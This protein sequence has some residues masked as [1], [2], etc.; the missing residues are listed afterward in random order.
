MTGAKRKSRLFS[1]FQYTQIM[2]LF[3]NPISENIL[4][5]VIDHGE[6]RQ[7]STIPKG[8][9]YDAFPEEVDRMIHR[10]NI[11]TIWCI[12]WPWS[13]TRMR[14]VTLT[15]NTFALTENIK[16]KG[17]H[18]FEIINHQNPIL[19]AN[20]REYIVLEDDRPTLK[21]KEQLKVGKEYVGYGQKNDFTD[22]KNF[23]EY[24]LDIP[25]I[26]RIFESRPIETRLSP[27]YL[28]EPHITWS[29]KNT[30]PSSKTMS[31]SSWPSTD[32]G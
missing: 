19:I 27:I 10:H 20:N 9:D 17:C 30:Y 4:L 24:T 1:N 21:E 22:G 15:L 18:F 5:F 23:I 2:V 32:I 12:V 16:L 3:I 7:T 26:T 8:K 13:F 31:K 29:K 6:V 28:K 11:D 14:I 25:Y